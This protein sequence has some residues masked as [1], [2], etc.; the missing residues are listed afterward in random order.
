MSK[1]NDLLNLELGTIDAIIQ[2]HNALIS[3]IIE[4]SGRWG[5]DGFRQ[6]LFKLKTLHQQNIDRINGEYSYKKAEIG[7]KWTT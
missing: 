6:E 4:I 5:C 1:Q 2:L 3:E 7:D